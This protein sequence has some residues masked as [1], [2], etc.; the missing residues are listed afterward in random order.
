MR[1]LYRTI[2][3]WG[4]D[5]GG[6]ICRSRDIEDIFSVSN[7]WQLFDIIDIRLSS[8]FTMIWKKDMKNKIIY[9]PNIPL[10]NKEIR[11]YGAAWRN[12]A[13]EVNI[14]ISVPQ[15]EIRLNLDRSLET[16]YER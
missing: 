13:E 2:H 1:N 11:N 9:F 14:V 3:K 6:G 12:T 4:Y 8:Q 15:D 7:R 16:R 10:L 5:G